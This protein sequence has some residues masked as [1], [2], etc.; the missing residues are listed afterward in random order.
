MFKNL[1][2]N[3]LVLFQ[4]YA[5]CAFLGIESNV[6]ID[7]SEITFQ[8]IKLDLSMEHDVS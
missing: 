5:I 3:I 4:L 2:G 6:Y 7:I 1:N 8:K